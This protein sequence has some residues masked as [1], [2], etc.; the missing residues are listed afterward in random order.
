VSGEVLRDEAVKEVA[1]AE[2]YRRAAQR[3]RRAA[4]PH[5]DRGLAR[6]LKRLLKWI[7]WGEI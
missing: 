4:D 2:E 6:A 3:R 7:V 1:R 5:R